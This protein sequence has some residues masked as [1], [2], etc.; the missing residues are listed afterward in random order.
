MDWLLKKPM[1]KKPE[2]RAELTAYCML[3]LSGAPNDK[4]YLFSELLP[5]GDTNPEL[6]FLYAMALHRQKQKHPEYSDLEL[7]VAALNKVAKTAKKSKG[8]VQNEALVE[9]LKITKSGE[10]S[11]WVESRFK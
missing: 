10:L 6:M 4:V 11:A 1:H 3:W 7:Q 8:L 9:F 5:A 2:I